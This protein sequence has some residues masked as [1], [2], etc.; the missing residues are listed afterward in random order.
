VTAVAAL[1]AFGVPA[2]LLPDLAAAVLGT[3]A[4]AAALLAARDLGLRQAWGY[5][6]TL[7]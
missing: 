7:D 3:A 5:L 2:A 4:F 1:V 6:R